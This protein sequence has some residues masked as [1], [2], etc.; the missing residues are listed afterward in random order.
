MKLGVKGLRVLG[1]RVLRS[2]FL[3]FWGVLV[4]GI[5]PALSKTGPP[6]HDNLTATP[7]D[8]LLQ[9]ASSELERHK[10]PPFFGVL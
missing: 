6:E 4:W 5:G 7:F 3:G 2:F 8:L 1:F 10:G 9:W